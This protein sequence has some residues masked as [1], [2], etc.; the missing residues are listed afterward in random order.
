MQ[1]GQECVLLLVS[2]VEVAQSL[3]HVVDR[4]L[5]WAHSPHDC[6]LVKLVARFVLL[7]L[8]HVNGPKVRNVGLVQ[9]NA[10]RSND[11]LTKLGAKALDRVDDV[12]L[13]SRSI[14][15]KWHVV[16]GYHLLLER[17]VVEVRF[18]GFFAVRRDNPEHFIH[19]GHTKALE[20]PRRAI[21]VRRVDLYAQ[22]A[23][24]DSAQN[25]AV[26]FALIVKH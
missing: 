8:V 20:K 7:A 10:L 13:L 14:D 19:L 5:N 11:A 18:I 22:S 15:F 2:K 17:F 26:T 1:G 6:E 21:V 25:V 12:Q 24:V 16:K 3:Q 9:I 4:A 23:G